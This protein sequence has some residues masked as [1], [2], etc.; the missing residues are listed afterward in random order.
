M[1]QKQNTFFTARV[2]KA[3]IIWLKENLVQKQGVAH[4]EASA[5][6]REGLWLAGGTDLFPSP[7]AQ[8]GGCT[9]GEALP[10][11]LKGYSTAVV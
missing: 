1:K 7:V 5:E 9:A 3:S 11:Q 10:A 8:A 4:A 2:F 6:M